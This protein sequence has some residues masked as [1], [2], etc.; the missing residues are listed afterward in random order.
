MH[1]YIC[2]YTLIYLYLNIAP[3][4]MLVCIYYTSCNV[5]DESCWFIILIGSHH[6]Y[7][8]N[9]PG[10]NIADP[11]KGC[12]KTGRL[13]IF[14]KTLVARKYHPRKAHIC[15]GFFMNIYEYT[16]CCLK[17]FCLYQGLVSQKNRR[18]SLHFSSRF[19][20]IYVFF[21]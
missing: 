1:I 7:G 10:R 18:P 15:F 8:V 21:P 19:H 14:K 12:W 9:S 4:W 3:R 5:W 13:T 11:E 16:M 6:L 2:I 17:K 20:A